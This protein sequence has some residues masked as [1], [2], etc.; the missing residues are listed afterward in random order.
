[1]AI[2]G[3]AIGRASRH[4]LTFRVGAARYALEAKGVAEVVAIP[5]VA[6][7]PQAP[8]GLMGLANLRGEVVPVADIARLLQRESSPE[9]MERVIVMGGEAAVALAVDRV[10]ELV[11]IAEDKIE[12]QQAA[13]VALPG[14]KLE[15]AFRPRPDA[16]F[17][18]II[19]LPLLLA[20]AFTPATRGKRQSRQGTG[21]LAPLAAEGVNLRQTKFI[22]FQA[23]GQD[24]ALPLEAVEEI[25]NVPANITAL[26]RS[27]ALIL[28]VGALRDTLLPLMSLRG[29]LG[30][31]AAP[32]TGLGKTV[33]VDVKGRQVGL[34]VD[35]MT[36]IFSADDA[37]I[38]PVPD[39]LV[40][41]A[42]GE[43]RIKAIYRGEGRLVSI[44]SPDLLFGE[45]V[46]RK[47]GE[48]R[49]TSKHAGDA[50]TG[51]EHSMQLVV[52]GLGGE[53]FGLP[54]EAV[55]EVA[56]V[57]EQVSRLPKTPKFLEGV[58][59]LRGEVLAVIDQRKRFGLPA[60]DGSATR[61]LLVVRTGQHKAGLIVDSVAEV[62]RSSPDAVQPAPELA[63]ESAKLVA[64]V[65]NLE[66]TGRMI[67]ML[68]PAEL[69]TRAER[70]LMNAFAKSKPEIAQG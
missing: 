62:L 66:E 9:K 35:S 11:E 27:E 39:L 47:L 34:V 64:G 70:G 8:P 33:I 4:F 23:G 52:F 21:V 58:V 32:D 38:D 29:L 14:E 10:E 56:A 57:P 7:I 5:A 24:F 42:G 49:E 36:A 61:R 37:S 31:G 22:G 13:L 15:G 20:N 17:I 54:I 6:R 68:D 18:K 44:L 41:R 67:L 16:D 2:A 59:N 30:L 12:R 46:M 48:M 40:A 28:G 60:A 45:D 50:K 53:E 51:T 55:E 63:G 19:D 3:T 25:A 1:M 69:L 43:T 26:P 65:I